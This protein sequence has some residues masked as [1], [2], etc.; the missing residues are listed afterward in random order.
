MSEELKSGKKDYEIFLA[1]ETI[2]L[3]I[4]N[5][6]AIDRDGWHSW[7][8]D[9]EVT[10][11]SDFGHYPNTPELQVSYMESVQGTG[12]N[13]LALLIRPVSVDRVVGVASLS[14]IHPIHRAA[15]T[16]VVIGDRGDTR[17]ALFWGL[18]AKALLTQHAFE[19]LGLERVGGSQA[20]PLADWQRLQALFGFR[21]EG[22]KRRAF[23][24]GHESINTVTSSCTYQDYLAVK[25]ARDG[26]YWPGKEKLLELMRE[27]PKESIAESVEQ[28]INEAVDGYLKQV[29]LS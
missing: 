15:E 22:I 11:Y 19:T 6:L 23:R 2:D 18:E 7:F 9:P 28:A 10:R 17:G 1:G 16:A 27:L 4:P 3:V 25:E 8:N 5:R 20:M 14:N 21:P 24:R 13:R 12:S 29:K 26:A